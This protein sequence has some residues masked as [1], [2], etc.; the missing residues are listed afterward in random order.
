MLTALKAVMAKRSPEFRFGVKSL[1]EG[2][3]QKGSIE[4]AQQFLKLGLA[5]NNSTLKDCT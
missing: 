4:P 1:Y 2:G 5:T 3:P